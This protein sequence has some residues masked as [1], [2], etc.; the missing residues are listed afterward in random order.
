MTKKEIIKQLQILKIEPS[1][2]VPIDDLAQKWAGR[3]E[4]LVTAAFQIL[5]TIRKEI[6]EVELRTRCSGVSG[7]GYT[8]ANGKRR[9]CFH[10]GVNVQ[11]SAMILYQHGKV[12]DSNNIFTNTPPNR[13]CVYGYLQVAGL[14]HQR[15]V[16][17]C[18]IQSYRDITGR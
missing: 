17:D 18:L 4:L 9:E 2:D 16:T 3:D 13:K 15:Y 14:G 12:P 6:P 8:R 7:Y 1:V 11:P 10:V 5:S